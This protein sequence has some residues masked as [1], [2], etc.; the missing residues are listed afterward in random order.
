MATLVSSHFPSLQLRKQFSVLACQ[1]A[2]RIGF[3]STQHHLFSRKS[4]KYL[5]SICAVLS[6]TEHIGVSS[7]QSEDLSTTV[8][9]TG[10]NGGELKM[11]ERRGLRDTAA[12][13]RDAESDLGG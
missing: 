2:T 9:T 4:L 7:T 8:T 1:N 13:Q 3:G 5:P 6:G 10:N 12:E 11:R